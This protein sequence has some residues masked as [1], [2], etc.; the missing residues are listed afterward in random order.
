[1][2]D[3][4]TKKIESP[5][6][7][8]TKRASVAKPNAKSEDKIKLYINPSLKLTNNV[9]GLH[10]EIESIAKDNDELKMLRN[11]I[12]E[13]KEMYIN[14]TE[15]MRN[16]FQREISKFQQEILQKDEKYQRLKEMSSKREVQLLDESSQVLNNFKTIQEE[17]RQARLSLLQY[18]KKIKDQSKTIQL[19]NEAIDEFQKLSLNLEK[20]VRSLE[21]CKID[22]NM[23]T[24]I[25]Q[26]S[27]FKGFDKGITNSTQLTR[28]K[29][30]PIR[31]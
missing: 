9:K 18:D 16:S 21:T 7:V 22:N 30:C 2:P 1:M 11:E 20:E 12:N 6:K 25:G 26:R 14:H 24:T 28:S 13:I 4:E 10:E 15:A 23:E 8:S 27:S 31:L 5:K 29:S 19:Q 17:L 3:Y